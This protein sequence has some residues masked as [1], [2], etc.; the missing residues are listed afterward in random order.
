MLCSVYIADI[1]CH[2]LTKELARASFI[3]EP[4]QVDPMSCVISEILQKPHITLSHEHQPQCKNVISMRPDPRQLN[5]AVIAMM[6]EHKRKEIAVIIE[7]NFDLYSYVNFTAVSLQST[8][9]I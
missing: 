7:G 2:K 5:E 8:N 1:R 3:L 9:N 4:Y 6:L